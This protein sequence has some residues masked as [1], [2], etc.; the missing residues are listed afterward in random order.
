MFQKATRQ[1]LRFDSPKGLLCVEDLW[2]IPLTSNAGKANLD[3]IAK[4]LHRQLQSTD[5][6]SFVTVSKVTDDVNQ[7]KFDI[8]K[9]VIDT[10]LVE[11]AAAL[12]SRDNK[13]KKQRI[14]EIIERKEGDALLGASLEDLQKMA[15]S[16]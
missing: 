11:N 12:L 2:D 10:R 16:L 4:G 15:A 7:L 14:L 9:Q 5:D 6:Q 8:V 3:D 13:E 1:K